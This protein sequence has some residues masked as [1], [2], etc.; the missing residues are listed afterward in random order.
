MSGPFSG[1]RATRVVLLAICLGLLPSCGGAKKPPK[2][3]YAGLTA[4]QI[5]QIGYQQLKKGKWGKARETFQKALGRPTST[6]VVIA[7]V[8]LGLADAYFYDGGVL[9]LA[10]ALS[11]YT[12]FLTF[13]PDHERAAYAQYQLGLCYLRQT[14]SPDR[15]Q[16]E[17]RKALN[18][19]LKVFS[20]YPDSEY[21]GSAREKADEAR[22]KL[23]EYEFRIGQFYFKNRGY[24]GAVQRFRGVIEQ[25]PSYSN[26][27]KLY[28]LLGRSLIALHRKEEGEFYLGK[29]LSDYPESHAA[30]QARNLLAISE[31][32]VQAGE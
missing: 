15:D 7:K 27:P 6:P 30:Y 12:N 18:A 14:L 29:L 23:A 17:T 10:E 9:N 26:M 13:Y 24:K 19:F 5:Y 25:Y 11:R 16:T 31:P 28:L 4:E 20:F 32:D 1:A 2:D 8:H 21:V 22:E 3:K